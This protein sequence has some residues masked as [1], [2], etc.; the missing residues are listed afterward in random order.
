MNK[1]PA[2]LGKFSDA[3]AQQAKA[4]EEFKT[5]PRFEIPNE[6]ANFNIHTAD[7]TSERQATCK[8]EIMHL[9]ASQM[10]PQPAS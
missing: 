6:R 1:S 8:L 5:S 3:F 9:L 4:C 7:S 2:T 10:A